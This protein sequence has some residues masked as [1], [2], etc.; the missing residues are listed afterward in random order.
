MFVLWTD[1][2]YDM[3]LKAENKFCNSLMSESGL[4]LTFHKLST[5]YEV[6]GNAEPI[7]TAVA[8][9]GEGRWCDAPPGLTVNFGVI[10]AVFL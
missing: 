5:N 10:F 2:N 9:S 7:V 3:F 6:S 8:Y 1:I 4:K